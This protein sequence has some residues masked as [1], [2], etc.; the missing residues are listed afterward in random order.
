MN[1]IIF[2]KDGCEIVLRVVLGIMDKPD[3]I[4]DVPE[5]FWKGPKGYENCAPPH[6]RNWFEC[7]R[8]RRRPH[9]DVE[10]GHRS[11]TLCH[12]GT[13]AREVRRRIRWDPEKEVCLNDDE[14]TALTDRPR[15]KGFELPKTL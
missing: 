7:M 14:A 2:F 11:V 10:I 6:L 1:F 3:F 9:A 5:P 8:N 15:R 4:K 12:L 13:I